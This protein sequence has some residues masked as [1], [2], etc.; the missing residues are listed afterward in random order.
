MNL[1]HYI[2]FAAGVLSVDVG[3]NR[4]QNDVIV[5]SNL[6]VVDRS[7]QRGNPLHRVFFYWLF[8]YLI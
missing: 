7:N 8:V 3:V 6:H 5:S 1:I 2:I 4:N